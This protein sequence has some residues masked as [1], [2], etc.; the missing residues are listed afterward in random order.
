MLVE[1]ASKNKLELFNNISEDL[2]N[3]I[4]EAESMY[5]KLSEYNDLITYEELY[6]LTDDDKAIFHDIRD[7]SHDFEHELIHIKEDLLMIL[8]LDI[9]WVLTNGNSDD[10]DELSNTLRNS[11]IYYDFFKFEIIL[12]LIFDKLKQLNVPRKKER[13]HHLHVHKSGGCC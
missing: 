5:S 3:K 10:S 12:S 9:E 8:E 4:V 1:E 13:S 6:D 7:K 2:K 11:Q